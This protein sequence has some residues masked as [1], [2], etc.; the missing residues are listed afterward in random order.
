MRKCNYIKM[1]KEEEEEEKI[2]QL[3]YNPEIPFAHILLFIALVFAQLE[4]LNK[5]N[6]IR[7]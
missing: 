2:D 4:C 5:A 7:R 1:Q 6:S 3:I